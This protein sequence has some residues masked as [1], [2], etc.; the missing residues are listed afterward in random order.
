MRGGVAVLRSDGS[1]P[2]WSLILDKERSI[3]L[4]IFGWGKSR[5][6]AV[7]VGEFES[8]PY[9]A[10][11]GLSG[12][13]KLD[14]EALGC[15]GTG[16]GHRERCPSRFESGIGESDVGTRVDDLVF[17]ESGLDGEVGGE[18]GEGDGLIWFWEL[19][20]VLGDEGEFGWG[21]T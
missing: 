10:S 8:I 5:G 15:V 19:G 6:T 17:G 1:G 12:G 7:S 2:G 16:A 11:V 14:G 13:R 4:W 20:L 21:G 9:E 3:G 18:Q